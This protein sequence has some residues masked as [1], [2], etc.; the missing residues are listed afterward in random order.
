M[1]SFLQAWCYESRRAL[2]LGW[3]YNVGRKSRLAS[4]VSGNRGTSHDNCSIFT[5]HSAGQPAIGPPRL[6]EVIAAYL[7]KVEL[8]VKR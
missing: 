4:A 6:V 7:G 8:P 2:V 5:T 1:R 3:R